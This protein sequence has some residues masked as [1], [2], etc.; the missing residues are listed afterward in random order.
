MTTGAGDG[1]GPIPV[2]E[3]PDRSQYTGVRRHAR[4]RRRRGRVTIVLVVLILVPVLLLGTGVAWFWYQLG[5]ESNG[6]TVSVHLERGWGVS[7][8]GDELA[9]QHIVRSA[10]AFNIYARFNGD[11]SFQAGTYELRQ[12]LGV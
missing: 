6:N 5:G 12:K 3:F 4:G 11:N 9:K 8:V 2:D 1:G 10:L 7:Q